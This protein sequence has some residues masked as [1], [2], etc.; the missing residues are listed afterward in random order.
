MSNYLTI[1]GGTTNTRV[2]LVMDNRVIAT[3]KI[4]LGS[5]DCI[6]GN[7]CLKQE[8]HTKIQ[9]LLSSNNLTEQD[10]T[11]VL[12]SGMITCEYGLCEVPHLVAPAGIRE[13][14]QGL[15][16]RLI[17]D[18]ISKPIRF[19]PGVKI[20][21]G[22]PE[23]TD[24]MRGEETELVGLLT[25]DAGSFAYVLPGS[26]SKMIFL[27]DSGRITDFKTMM[28]GEMIAALSQN[29]I[30]REA[31]D[32]RIDKHDTEF[33]LAGYDYCIVHG[34]NEA[35]FKV[36]ILKN[37]FKETAVACYSYFLGIILANEIEVL[38]KS[39]KA[40]VVL[41]G[42]SQ[43]KNAMV[44]ILKART[45]LKVITISDEDAASCVSLGAI[46]IFEFTA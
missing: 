31:V 34:I 38:K 36:R 21:G 11:A 25:E 22:T 3:E 5:K 29:T 26:H 6:D 30:L 4:H 7:D 42:R 17:P 44:D 24:M 20:M 43:I 10:I 9:S 12:A 27:D 33:L 40:G 16:E 45:E 39:G 19:V 35:L 18:V 41:G 8:L 46:K 37:I 2:S 32:L 15:Q 14:H 1:D 28:T 23:Y 13:L